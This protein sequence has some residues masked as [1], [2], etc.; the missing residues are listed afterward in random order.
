MESWPARP[1]AEH[2]LKDRRVRVAQGDVAATLAA[3]PRA[4]DAILLDVDNGPAAFTTN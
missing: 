1:L 4:F 3:S 2:P